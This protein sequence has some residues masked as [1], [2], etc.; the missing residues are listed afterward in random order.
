M[1]AT[2]KPP[3]ADQVAAFKQAV[4]YL[5]LTIFNDCWTLQQQAYEKGDESAAWAA[6]KEAWRARAAYDEIEANLDRLLERLEP[7]GGAS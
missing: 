2:T 6:G 4:V 3:L 7:E 1:S 5:T